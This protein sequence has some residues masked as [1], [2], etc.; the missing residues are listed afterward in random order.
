MTLTGS[1]NHVPDPNPVTQTFDYNV[2]PAELLEWIEHY[3]YFGLHGAEA[4][5]TGDGTSDNP[6]KFEIPGKF[7]TASGMY[8]EFALAAA[9][10]GVAIPMRTPGVQPGLLDTGIHT[11]LVAA[12]QTVILPNDG[13]GTNNSSVMTIRTDMAGGTAYGGQGDNTIIGLNGV[14]NFGGGPGNDTLQGGGGNDILSGGTDDDTVEGGLGNDQ[15]TGNSGNDTLIGDAGND[16]LFGGSGNDKLDGGIGEDE[17][18][19]GKL[20]YDK[21][22]GGKGNDTFVFENDWGYDVVTESRQ[23]GGRITIAGNKVQHID[24][25]GFLASH[26]TGHAR[27]DEWFGSFP[28]QATMHC[29]NRWTRSKVSI[30]RTRQPAT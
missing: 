26:Q 19:G 6:W 4:E 30:R 14:D 23:I 16:K 13:I 10:T 20:D 29:P 3:P 8:Y 7:D 12:N 15:L 18:H 27:A 9:P 11:I 1:L 17:L 22:E 24:G 5:V 21:L 28:E 25:A 2:S